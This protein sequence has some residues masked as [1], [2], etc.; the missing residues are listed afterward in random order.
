MSILHY[1]SK[2]KQT[3]RNLRKAGIL[4]E[5]LLWQQLKSKKL[6]GL[7]FTRQ[8]VIGSYIVDFY[9]A[10]NK[11]VIEIDG[12]SHDNND[13]H[14]K[15]IL[16]D[17]YLRNLGIKVIRITAKDVLQNINGVVELLK[18]ETKTEIPRQGR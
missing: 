1:N 15:D 5:V 18:Q 7:N 12:H 17:K 8:K 16:R 2:L 10:A 14:A 3:S 4:H 11:I 13:K 9:N 6:N